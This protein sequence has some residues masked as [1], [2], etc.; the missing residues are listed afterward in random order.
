ML[1]KKTNIDYHM[2]III[3]QLESISLENIKSR[4]HELYLILFV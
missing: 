2:C 1:I 4:G 3:V